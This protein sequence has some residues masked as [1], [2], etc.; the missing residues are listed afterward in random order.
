MRR[1]IYW[2]IPI[3]GGIIGTIQTFR[4]GIG[5]HEA[6]DN[7]VDALCGILIWLVLITFGIIVFSF[8]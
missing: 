6:F 4:I 1:L 8:L 7:Q 5:T 2:G 3:L